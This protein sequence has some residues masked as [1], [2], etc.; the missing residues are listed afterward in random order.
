M[1]KKF[2]HPNEQMN[3]ILRGVVELREREELQVKLQRSF[4]NNQPLTIMAGFDPSTPDLHLGHTVLLRKMRQFQD[5]GHE[6]IFLIGDFTAR[7]GD[8]SGQTQSRPTISAKTVA[9]NASTYEK[10]ISHIL[11]PSKT[12]IEFNSTWLEPL[13]FE[14]ILRLVNSV[15]LSSLASRPDLCDRSDLFLGEIL[16]PLLQ[17]YDSIHLKVDVEIGGADQ[18]HNLLL[19]RELM[20]AYGLEP[21]CILATDL[22]E[23]TNVIYKDGKTTGPKMSKTLFNTIGISESPEEIRKKIHALDDGVVWHYFQLLTD[24]SMLQIRAYQN[25]LQEGKCK[26]EEIKDALTDN[27]LSKTR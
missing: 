18:I 13:R 6:V 3:I 17:A 23:G 4:D 25:D 7:F 15:P 19:G 26:M 14:E 5:L 27:L 11:D 21:Q 20:S 22:L 9:H 12:R 2:A 24:C 1:V 8:P 10:Q 16:Y